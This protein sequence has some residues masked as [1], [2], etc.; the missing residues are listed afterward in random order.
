MEGS[1][2]IVHSYILVIQMCTDKMKTR[3]AG[4]SYFLESQFSDFLIAQKITQIPK[5]LVTG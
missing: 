3:R 5:G 1:L 4:V 2:L